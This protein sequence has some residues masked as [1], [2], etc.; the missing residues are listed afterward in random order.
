ME[1][2]RSGGGGR[3]T[4]SPI[5][6]ESS[7][8]SYHLLSRAGGGGGTPNRAAK[9]GKWSAMK[10]GKSKDFAEKHGKNIKKMEALID[11][12]NLKKESPEQLASWCQFQS[13]PVLSSPS[14]YRDL[15]KYLFNFSS[16][17]HIF[18]V[19]H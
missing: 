8:D 18:G 9:H 7:W 6:S 2:L 10:S 3:M 17:A 14:Q 1:G 4:P 11:Q 16:N 15:L 5:R 19:L 13:G 12:V